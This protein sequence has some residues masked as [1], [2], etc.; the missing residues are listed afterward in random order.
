[1]KLRDNFEN[2]AK[3]GGATRRRCSVKRAVF[4]EQ[5]TVPWIDAVCAAREGMEHTLGP[6]ATL[7][8]SQFEDDTVA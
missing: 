8:G 4:V 1:M 3:I 2:G 5:V 7:R 6:G